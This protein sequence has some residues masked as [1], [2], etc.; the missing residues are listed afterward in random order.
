MV[1][2]LSMENFALSVIAP[3]FNEELNIP[4]LSR[5]V[6]EVFRR[7]KLKGELILVDDGSSD[8]TRA[9][10]EQAEKEYPGEVVGRF[11]PQNMGIAHGWKT[12]VGAARAPVVAVIDADLQYQPEDLL[13][14]Y[15]ALLEHSVDVVQGWRSAVGRERG[16]RY[17]LSRGLNT[18]LNK[19]FG[20]DL[21]DN[22][23]GFVMCAKE[24][25]EDLLTYRGHYYYW[26]SFIMVA[27]HAKGY[28]YKQIE[29]LFENRRAGK[30]FLDGTAYRA[31]AKALVDL[32]KAAWEYRIRQKPK[33]VSEQFLRRHPVVDRSKPMSPARRV[34]W[35]AYLGFFNQTHWMITRDVER[36]YELLRKTQW[37]SPTHLRDLQDEK[38][39]RLVRHA[40][41]NVPYYR[42][43]M[44]E[45]GIRPEDIRGQADLYKL[46]FLTKQDVR[47]HVYFDILSE[48]HDKD[49]VLRITTSGSTGEPFVCFAD[50]A[51]LEFRWSATL[52]SQEWTGYEFGDPSVRL[53]H[54]TLG[55]SKSQALK[56]QLDAKL[57][58][59][60][61]IPVFEMSDD[62]LDEMVRE[63]A[64]WKPVLMDGYA[65]ALDFLAHYLKTKGNVDVRPRALMSSAQT[66]P[67]TSRKLIEEAFGCKVFDKYGSREFSG[68]AY[69]CEAHTG[70]HIVGE[71]Y[72]VE[73]LRDGEPARP[74]E[75]GEVVVTDLN[76]FCLPFIRYRIG[77]LAV[78]M[79]PDF[80]CPCG[81]G[82]PLLGSIEGR[83]QS[84]IQ[85]TDRR[86]VPGT[87]FAHYLKEFDHAI[88]RF[89]VVQE[90]EGAMTFRVVKGGRY[91]DDAL[92][93]IL[94]T[95]REYLGSDMQIDVEFV[96]NIDMV[97]TGKRL[98]SVSRLAVD[99]QS[100]APRRIDTN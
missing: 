38:L 40:Y 74:G 8:G 79:D 63:I 25:M 60:K 10:I 31:S 77:D 7:G 90:R 5:R 22:K 59:R 76:N 94:A 58:R 34:E 14:L 18:L 95:F 45:A 78:A 83:V 48:N 30:S 71:G 1:R 2:P 12:G 44:R 9:A 27:A 62:K 65:E 88:Q 24:V 98:A 49:E 51:Q 41:R 82:L 15:H 32:G 39:R 33:D 75:V 36:Y 54:Q 93:E 11:H 91:S 80:E 73:I 50:R 57:S 46:P 81:R 20:M 86:Y 67:E 28:S 43:R 68:I 100:G 19:T 13:R 84:I 26:Q 56:E 96:E 42:H 17:N 52:R 23:S 97:R 89:Q 55:M 61:F 53:W 3:C 69:E 66:L 6:V 29:T 70:H 72:I 87:F 35:Q 21:Q 37:L 16:T 64:D 92:Q 47:D 99:F 85:G 4:E